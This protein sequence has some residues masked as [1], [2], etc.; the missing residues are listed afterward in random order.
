[1]PTYNRVDLLHET[2]KTILSQ[3]YEDLELLIVDDGSTDKTAEV[4]KEIQAQD[5]RLRYIQLPE[6][7]G[8]GF[9]RQAGLENISGKFIALADSDDLW[10][11]G[12]LRMQVEVLEKYPE[13]EILFGNFR[14]IN[15]IK[16][17]E[18]SG[19]VETQAGM[20]DLVIN[21]LE[22]ELWLVESGIE[23]GIL[24]SNF[25]QPATILLRVGVIKKVG[26][27]VSSQGGAI[28][29]D[30][31][32]CWRAAVFE[33]RYAYINRVLIERHK[34]KTSVTA[35]A[36][37]S[38][39][40]KLE[41]LKQIHRTCKTA[42]RHDLLPHIRATERRVWRNLIRAYSDRG[43][44]TKIWWAFRQSLRYG[45]SPRT[46]AFFVIGMCGSQAMAFAMKLRARSLQFSWKG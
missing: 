12:K 22:D 34:Y 3:D 32:F 31:E 37:D 13:I 1:M 33:V 8:I 17:T 21:H 25:V 18:A 35:N 38:C 40:Q 4:I 42:H 24:K 43:E 45:F 16:G 11:P 14:N 7:R 41:I 19:F 28:H 15:H 5:Q 46:F 39:I 6:N 20:A 9:A 30:L 44:R 29:P 23:T 10:L 36:V 26:G 2:I 27:F